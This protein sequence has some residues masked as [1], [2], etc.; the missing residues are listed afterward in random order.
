MECPN[1]GRLLTRLTEE[2]AQTESGTSCPHCWAHI[3]RLAPPLAQ[4]RVVKASKKAR[5]APPLRR[6]A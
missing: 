3:R 5:S 2:L 1:C 6:A 4:V